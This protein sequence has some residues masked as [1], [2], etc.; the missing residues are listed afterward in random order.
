MTTHIRQRHASA[1][2][3]ASLGMVLAAASATAQITTFSVPGAGTAAGQEGTFAGHINNRGE[4]VGNYI[5]AN[6]VS[7]G[8]LRN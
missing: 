7:Y 1:A 4:L 8:F 6:N 2:C 5:D 3:I